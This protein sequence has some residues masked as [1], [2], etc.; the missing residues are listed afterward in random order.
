[1]PI[2]TSKYRAPHLFK[3][4]HVATVYSGLFR[5]V[6]GVDQERERITLSDGDFLD[7]DWSFSKEK[8]NKLIILLHG[9]EGN[10][11]RPYLLGPAKLFNRN[12]Y[13]A[14][15]VNFRGC[16]GVPNLKYKSYHSGATHDLEQIIHHIVQNKNYDEIHI[17]GFSLGANITLKYFGER[18]E[19]PPQVKSAIA[20]SVPCYL[21][22]S[23]RELHTFKNV[24]YANRFKK[25]L[26]GRLKEKQTRFPDQIS[27]ADVKSIRTL[28]DFDDVYTSK[29]H[30]FRD[31]ED[32]YAKCSSLQFLSHIKLPTLILNAKND[33]FLSEE[34][35]PYE[36]A[37]KNA[38]L[39]LEVP[40]HGGHVGFYEPDS[41]YYNE[42]RALN[43][44]EELKHL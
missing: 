32:Y 44:I 21:S 27:K 20:V 15:C 41:V 1:M 14:V 4:G 36:I 13:D 9:L 23:A 7:L 26:L 10:A 19:F 18:Q 39:F 12:N 3:N 37:D 38:N 33:S 17:N 42:S 11:Q 34:C 24:L 5:T 2:V 25:H 29:A 40:N 43:F 6:K 30:G 8:S 35:F 22:G 28:Y 16:S 31:A